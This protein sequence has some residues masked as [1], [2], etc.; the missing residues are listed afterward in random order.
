ML[1]LLESILKIENKIV[2][3]NFQNSI[4]HNTGKQLCETIVFHVLVVD[5]S[6]IVLFSFHL[7]FIPESS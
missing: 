3:S 7:I 4:L 2:F 6:V 1:L 5:A